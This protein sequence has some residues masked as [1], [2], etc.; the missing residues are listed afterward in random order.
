MMKVDKSPELN[1]GSRRF[2][3]PELNGTV[4]KIFPPE[5]DN[6]SDEQFRIGKDLD[7]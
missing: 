6:L 2:F 4:S 7:E 5:P 3:P 1:G